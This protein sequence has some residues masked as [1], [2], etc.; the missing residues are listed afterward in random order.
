MC[1]D[2]KKLKAELKLISRLNVII[3]IMMIFSLLSLASF[4]CVCLCAGSFLMRLHNLFPLIIIIMIITPLKTTSCQFLCWW[5]AGRIS[6]LLAEATSQLFALICLQTGSLS[7]NKH[8]LFL[9]LRN[10]IEEKY[11]S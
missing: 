10:R 4:M 7:I 9:L 8:L 2:H 5:P 1:A 3:T 6:V 11:R